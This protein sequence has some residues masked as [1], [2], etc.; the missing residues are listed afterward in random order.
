MYYNKTYYNTAKKSQYKGSIYDSKFEAGYAIELDQRLKAKEI[1]GW[2]KQVKIA[3]DVNNFH[4]CNYYVDF[5]ITHKDDTV[6]FVETKGYPTPE[7][8]LKWK[9][10]EAL[11]S[12]IPGIIL[13]VVNQGNFKTPRAKKIKYGYK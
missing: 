6:E 13:T 3:L 11:Y 5:K 4:I 10:F 1:K 12:E 9:L 8:K 2:E 7:W